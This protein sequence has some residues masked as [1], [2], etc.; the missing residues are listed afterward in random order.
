MRVNIGHT[1]VGLCL[2]RLDVDA[3]G[4]DQDNRVVLIKYNT[5]GLIQITRSDKRGIFRRAGF[6]TVQLHNQGAYVQLRHSN[7][8]LPLGV[9]HQRFTVESRREN[10][11]ILTQLPPEF[12]ALASHHN[13]ASP[14]PFTDPDCLTLARQAIILLNNLLTTGKIELQIRGGKLKGK[15]HVEHRF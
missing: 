4:L 12:C 6:H 3:L 5:A 10:R 11:S 13:A 15:M 9:P 7:F 1:N 14:A 2:D 8:N